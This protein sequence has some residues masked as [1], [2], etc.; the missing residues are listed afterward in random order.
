MEKG[1]D[2]LRFK[3]DKKVIFA[4]F[5]TNLICHFYC[6]QCVDNQPLYIQV[7]DKS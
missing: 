2:V 3:R 4:K 6:F 5:L 7:I 1:S